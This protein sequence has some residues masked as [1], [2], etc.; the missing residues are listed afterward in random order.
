MATPESHTPPAPASAAASETATAPTAAAAAA[1]RRIPGL[2]PGLVPPAPQPKQ[3]KRAPKK[4]TIAAASSSPSVPATPNPDVPI[5]PE[6]KSAGNDKADA[7]EA[8][9]LLRLQETKS[10]A[11]EVVQKRLRATTKKVQR[12]E[13]YEASTVALNP[14][15]QRA[16]QGKSALQAVVRELTE[17]SALLKSDD[18][19]NSAR[20]QRLRTL[21]EKQQ[22]RAVEAATKI[23]Q[24][25]AQSK[26][27]FLFQFLHLHSLVN[28][29]Q[30]MMMGG[31]APAPE[32]PA[33][34]ESASS[35]D[36]AAV[37]YLAD[38]FANGPLLGGGD[39]ATEKLAHLFEGS[40]EEVLQGQGVSYRRVR[41][42]VHG[43]TAPPA[44]T[45]STTLAAEGAPET[46]Q[47]APPSTFGA[48]IGSS[49]L[50]DDIGASASVPGT[51]GA[52]SLDSDEREHAD[53]PAGPADSVVALV[54]GA[55]E[56]EPHPVL[57]RPTPPQQQQSGFP[58]MSFLQPSEVDAAVASAYQNDGA[59]APG[60]GLNIDLAAANAAQG[61]SPLH[62]PGAETPRAEEKVQ[63]WADDLAQDGQLPPPEE[64]PTPLLTPTLAAAPVPE[65]AQVN[66]QVSQ[67][68]APTLDWAADD[69][70]GGLPHLPEL[71][72]AVPLVSAVGDRPQQQQQQQSRNGSQAVPA[73][74]FQPARPSRRGSERGS[75]GGG[76]F[77]GGRG[78]GLSSRGSFRGR[79]GRG[80]ANGGPRGPNGETGERP[81]RVEGGGGEF[82]ERRG[83]FRGGRGAAGGGGR[84]R[85]DSR[86]G[87]SAMRGT[88]STPV[89]PDAKA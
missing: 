61:V 16:V 48:G 50:G 78:R 26:L 52:D 87:R 42:L 58:T 86:G 65:Q 36:I 71:A 25:D 66:G 39:D 7:D 79:G 62:G 80:G 9:E 68:E 89:A 6:A 45:A 28:P 54:D 74:G 29:Q 88:Y 5:P 67:P 81:P 35:Q 34:L 20:Q 23:A 12:I 63:S 40:Q 3:R 1:S 47:T 33:I 18:E 57:S 41:Y 82:V 56:P 60:A 8:D 27:V 84:G 19:E 37:R 22:T 15:Q 76:S 4:Q 53:Q 83:S 30:Q 49:D 46:T 38:A 72:P 75:R 43:L 13:G 14:D 44:S 59:R 77:E 55:L 31:F 69:E 85:G 70:D 10:N 21:Y 51:P 17:L 73:D 64:T 32:L 24:K 11:A 2:A